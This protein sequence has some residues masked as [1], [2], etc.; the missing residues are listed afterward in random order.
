MCGIVGMITGFNNGFSHPEA[1]M[2]QDMMFLDS[3]RGVDATGIM[4]GDTHNNVSGLKE[5]SPSWN[6]MEK[7][8]WR[9]AKTAIISRGKWAVAHNRAATRGAKT[10]ENAHPF[11][12]D[13]IV[14]VQNGTYRGSHDHHAKVDVDSHACA[15]ALSKEDDVEKALKTINAAYAF[16]WWNHKEKSLNIIRNDERPLCIARTKS[17][18]LA[19]ASEG[20][21][22][23]VAAARNK[24]DLVEEPYLLKEH[25]LCKYVFDKG[26]YTVS[27][28]DMDC[29]FQHTTTWPS[30]VWTGNV[31]TQKHTEH[32]QQSVTQFKR[33]R[34]SYSDC[35]D[36]LNTAYHNNQTLANIAREK[37]NKKP[38]TEYFFM[39]FD[40]FP[41]DRG[42]GIDYLVFA[43]ISSTD[44]MNEMT[45][46]WPITSQSEKEMMDYSTSSFLGKVSHWI[47]HGDVVF[48][49]MKEV[50]EV[51]CQ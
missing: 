44:E 45:V 15:I 14:L 50:K 39:G 25:H 17:G 3:M 37:V 38:G 21:M 5:A 35:Y 34:R 16:V 26:D 20:W 2:L 8:E 43:S 51:I 49:V 9:D 18:G 30:S 11:V 41:L 40:Y 6:F 29:K 1:V 4:W 7:Q 32:Q 42:G 27:F 12:A 19:F 23:A 24:V 22:I 46:C 10:D 36:L 48:P 13:H 47:Q 28:T 33:T 31:F